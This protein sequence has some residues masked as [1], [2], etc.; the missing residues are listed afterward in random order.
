MPCQAFPAALLLLALCCAGPAAAAGPDCPP[1]TD[2]AA[3][4]VAAGAL[5]RVAA[6]LKAGRLEVLAIGS[7]TVLGA[8]G[9][10]EGGFPDRMVQDLRARFPKA[11]IHLTVQG[12]RGMGAAAM[13]VAL[14][15]NLATMAPALVVWQTGTVEAVRRVPTADFAGTL[16]D[17]AEAV[18][19]AGADLVLVDQPYSRM[20]QAYALLPPYRDAMQEAARRHHAVLFS[21]FELIR[22]WVQAGDLDLET[23]AKPD[24]VKMAALLNACLGEALARTVV[25]AAGGSAPDP[26]RDFAPGP[27]Q[28]PEALGTHY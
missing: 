8:R 2:V 19:A 28:G 7:G 4:D 3:P 15:R 20:L 6:A 24:R 23:A 10:P 11:E 16:D 21:R 22:Q 13:L 5:P 18:Q 14:R 27:H 12:E 17:G 9:R 25:R 1:A 26:A